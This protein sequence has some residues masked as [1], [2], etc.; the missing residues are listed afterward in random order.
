MAS[1]I[2]RGKGGLVTVEVKG[3]DEVLRGMA[4]FGNLV[5]DLR[6]F[7]TDVFA[8]AY[9]ARVQDIFN[10][11]G[12]TR[13]PTGR[14]AGG[15]WAALSPKY[16]AWKERHYPGRKIL[17][18]EGPLQASLDWHGGLGAGGVFEATGQYAR[19]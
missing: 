5:K 3:R 10:L 11:E 8:P 7:W 12:Q 1:T 14:F 4:A 17:S 18:R 2:Y 15:R 19:F 16:K 9:F 6:P 13:T